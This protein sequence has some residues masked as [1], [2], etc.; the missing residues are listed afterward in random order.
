MLASFFV[1]AALGQ[2]RLD[3]AED[4]VKLLATMV[5]NK[6]VDKRR[7]KRLDQQENRRVPLAYQ[8]RAFAL[9]NTLKHGATIVPLLTLGVAAEAFGVDTVLAVSPVLL[10]V[11]AM[12]LV[13]LSFVFS[14]SSPRQR[15]DV[16]VTFWQES[17]HPVSTPDDHR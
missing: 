9:Q 6:V 14:R 11:V 5:R 15:L 17:D 10:F 12:L 4:L 7:R 1:R 13:R 3:T 8:G 2:Y 16:L